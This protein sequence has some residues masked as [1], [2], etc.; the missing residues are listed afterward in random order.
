MVHSGE[1]LDMAIEASRILFGNATEETLSRIPEEMFLSV[2]EGVPHFSIPGEK[3]D[4]DI[5]TLLTEEAPVFPSRGELRRLVQGGGLSINKKKVTDPDHQVVSGDY[6]NGRYLLVQ[7]GKRNY[8][9][10]TVN[11][12]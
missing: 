6:I 2:F 11:S 3:K 12:N 8:F 9:L 1:D 5:M 10:I 7:K 4:A